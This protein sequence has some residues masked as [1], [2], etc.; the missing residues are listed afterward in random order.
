ME[1][2][3]LPK[4]LN[5]QLDEVTKG[6]EQLYNNIKTIAKYS[7]RHKVAME[8]E[9]K[10]D[11]EDRLL[12]LD[13]SKR[14]LLNTHKANISAIKHI[15]D[16]YESNIDKIVETDYKTEFKVKNF[17]TEVKFPRNK[18]D[19]IAQ[20]KEIKAEEIKIK[21]VITETQT[22]QVKNSV[23]VKKTKKELKLLEAEKEN[24]LDLIK[25]KL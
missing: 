12:R 6:V 22:P 9:V 7:T 1:I 4:E 18:A 19:V 13:D 20:Y 16:Q 21:T 8:V 17:N 11:K 25:T 10:A 14:E 3:N 15:L 2:T 24:F 23:E 5:E